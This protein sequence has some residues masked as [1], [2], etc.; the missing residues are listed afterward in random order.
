MHLKRDLLEMS[1]M[2][3]F[4]MDTIARNLLLNLKIQKPNFIFLSELIGLKVICFNQM[5]VKLVFK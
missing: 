3:H 1:R 2:H 5:H 4:G